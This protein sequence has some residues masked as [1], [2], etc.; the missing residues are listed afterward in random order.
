MFATDYYEIAK[1]RLQADKDRW[2]Q[3]LI[4]ENSGQDRVQFVRGK[5]AGLSR[6]LDILTDANDASTPERLHVI[7]GGA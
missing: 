3:A 6:A 2:V 5:I 1:A 7:D 4:Q